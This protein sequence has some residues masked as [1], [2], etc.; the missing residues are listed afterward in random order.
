M[1]Q[2]PTLL[3]HP[4]SFC[5][6]PRRCAWVGKTVCSPESRSCCSINSKRF[7]YYC[8]FPTWGRT[9]GKSTRARLPKSRPTREPAVRT[10][11]YYHHH[12]HHSSTITNEV[13]CT[14]RTSN[15]CACYNNN[16]KRERRQT[17]LCCCP[18]KSESSIVARKSRF[19]GMSRHVE[20]CEAH[21]NSHIKRKRPRC[22]QLR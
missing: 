18:L 10:Y 15:R 20:V 9:W 6:R 7:R 12:H 13:A 19:M 17:Q 4:K 21:N 1:K 11:H 16:R 5:N 3:S 8:E 22:S 14:N 2:Q